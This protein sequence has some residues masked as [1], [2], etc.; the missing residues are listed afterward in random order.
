MKHRVGWIFFDLASTLIDESECDRQ[1]ILRMSEGTGVSF[2]E[3]FTVMTEQFRRGEKGDKKAAEQ[4]G[5]A[6]PRWMCEYE[7]L[8]PDAAECLERLS[9]RYR[10]GVIANQLPGTAERLKKFGIDGFFDVVIAS[11]EEGIAKPDQAI[12]R[13]ALDRAG[14]APQE[15]AM[16]GDRPDN[17]IAPANSLG[18][19]TIRIMRGFSQYAM[20]RSAVETPDFTIQH[21]KEIIFLSEIQTSKK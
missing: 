21:L 18:M 9:E 20:P 4:F 8:Y 12:F 10:L 13:L 17:D 6:L 16:V 14:C 5:F 7:M 19:T 15:A 2:D 3:L 1:G 11:A